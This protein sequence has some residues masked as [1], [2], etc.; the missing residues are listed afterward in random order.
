MAVALIENLQREDLNPIEQAVAIGNMI[1]Q[2]EMTHQTAAEVLGKSRS[3]VSNLVRLLQLDR[4]VKA[5][6]SKGDIEMGHAR[7]LISLKPEDQLLIANQIIAGGLSVRQSE[8]LV[9]RLSR[10]PKESA[11]QPLATTLEKSISGW[12]SKLSKSLPGKLKIAH[13]SSGKGQIKISY[14]NWENLER[15]LA[16][17]EQ[18]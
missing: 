18:D 5:L 8:V 16:V 9:A 3:H 2:F 14:E 15:I 1:E 6:L 4:D 11:A 10:A 17:L 12:E 7:C 13:Q